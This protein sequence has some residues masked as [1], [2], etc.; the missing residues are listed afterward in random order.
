VQL[1]RDALPAL[2]ASGVQLVCVSIGTPARAL[3]FVDATGFPAA[4]LYIDPENECYDALALRHGW[5]ET[6]FDAAT[7]FAFRDRFV[8]DGAADLA[9]ILPRWQPCACACACVRA[10]ARAPGL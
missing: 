6:F 10:C 8:K 9:D 2:A 3:E 1:A 5:R 4:H 7:P